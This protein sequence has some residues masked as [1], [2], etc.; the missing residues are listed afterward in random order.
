MT[1]NKVRDQ[2]KALTKRLDSTQASVTNEL[3]RWALDN[4]SEDDLNS[5]NFIPAKKKGRK[6]KA[7]TAEAATPEVTEAVEVVE[8][9]VVEA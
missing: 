3:V 8:P 6:P 9:E 4:I 2:I 7:Q 5:L 1:E